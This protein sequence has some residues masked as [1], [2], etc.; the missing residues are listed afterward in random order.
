M[1][2]YLVHY[3]LVS[4]EDEFKHKHAAARVYAD[5][6]SWTLFTEKVK[7]TNIQY[8]SKYDITVVGYNEID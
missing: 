4:K 6:A 8:L 3:L 7:E 1:K 5:K 2:K